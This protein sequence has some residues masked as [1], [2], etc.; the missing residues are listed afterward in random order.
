[1][2]KGRFCFKGNDLAF[3][4]DWA[5]DRGEGRGILVLFIEKDY[6]V[7]DI[8]SIFPEDFFKYLNILPN[9]TGGL[10]FLLKSGKG[11]I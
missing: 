5:L 8:K 10:F 2:V 6:H 4:R 7:L 1:M 11:K 3:R 9:W